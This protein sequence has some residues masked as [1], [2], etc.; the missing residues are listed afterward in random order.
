VLHGQRI[1]FC[2]CQV[3]LELCRIHNQLNLRPPAH[4]LAIELQQAFTV[5]QGA[6]QEKELFAQVGARL[7]FTGIGPEEKGQMLAGLGGVGVERQIAK[8][9]LQTRRCQVCYG[10]FVVLEPEFAQ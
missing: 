4:S 5:G 10:T 7:C 6:P 2:R 1:L 9:R 3:L 8:Q